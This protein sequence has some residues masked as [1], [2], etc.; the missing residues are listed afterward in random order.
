MFTLTHFGMLSPGGFLFQNAL[1]FNIL[2]KH[3][4]PTPLNLKGSADSKIVNLLNINNLHLQKSA[5]PSSKADR[6]VLAKLKYSVLYKAES[7]FS[8]LT[9]ECLTFQTTSTARNYGTPESP[10]H[11]TV[12]KKL[13]RV[14][15]PTN[16]K[17]LSINKL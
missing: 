14:G 16:L 1:T 6:K 12:E 17:E 11:V 15:A 4:P 5:D 9:E 7:G 3:H 8:I 2:Q 10:S 13:T